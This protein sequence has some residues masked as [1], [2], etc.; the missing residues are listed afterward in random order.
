MSGSGDVMYTHTHTYID[1]TPAARRPPRLGKEAMDRGLECHASCEAQFVRLA[2]LS[3]WDGRAW[4]GMGWD[5]EA[6]CVVYARW[7][8]SKQANMAW[9]G[10]AGKAR[11]GTARQDTTRKE[12]KKT[13]PAF[14]VL[15]LFPEV[16]GDGGTFGGARW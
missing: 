8:A 14:Q 6:M 16:G 13:A 5:G 3:R 15:F 4:H 2:W 1:T 11:Q 9:H 10:M 12:K 7:F